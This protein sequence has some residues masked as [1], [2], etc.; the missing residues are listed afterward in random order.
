MGENAR[1]KNRVEMVFGPLLSNGRQRVGALKNARVEKLP[2]NI[3]IQWNAG[4]ACMSECVLKRLACRVCV[5][6]L[7]RSNVAN[8]PDIIWR[9]YGLCSLP[10]GRGDLALKVAPQESRI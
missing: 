4:A 10:T 5:S 2:L 7:L 9:V 6:A 8:S 3:R 1:F